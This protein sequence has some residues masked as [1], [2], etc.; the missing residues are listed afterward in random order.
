MFE[1][2]HLSDPHFTNN[3]D[4]F[5]FFNKGT[6]HFAEQIA[7]ALRDAGQKP[8]FVVASGDLTWDGDPTDFNLAKKFFKKLLT[9]LNLDVSKLLLIPG[10]HDI[11]WRRGQDKIADDKE[12][13]DAYRLFYEGL[14]QTDMSSDLTEI[15]VS[16]EATVVGLN[17]ASIESPNAAGIGYVGDEQWDECW[18][19]A[20]KDTAFNPSAVRIAVLHHHLVPVT[21]IEPH[22]TDKQFSLTL[23]AES[24]QSRLL[25]AGFTLVLHGHQHQPFLRLLSAPTLKQQ[26]CL[27]VAGAGSAGAGREKLGDGRRNH[28]QV[29]SIKD[30]EMAVQWY[31]LGSAGDPFAFMIGARYP[32]RMSDWPGEPPRIVSHARIAADKD[33]VLGRASIELSRAVQTTAQQIGGDH[34]LLSFF[35]GWI[36]QLAQQL[37]GDQSAL[38]VDAHYYRGCLSAFQSLGKHALAIADL[39]DDT[40]EFWNDQPDPL[41]TA[42]SE[43]L[44]LIA[45]EKMFDDL[46]LKK[47]HTLFLKHSARYKVWFDHVPFETEPRH[48]FGDRGRGRNLLLLDPD[49][50]GGYVN[51]KHGVFLRIAKNPALYSQA[52]AHYVEMRERS[53]EFDPT[54]STADLR[55]KWIQHHGFGRWNQDWK[56]MGTRTPDYFQ[57]YD[58]HIQTWIP[59]YNEF[60]KFAARHTMSSIYSALRRSPQA[61]RVLEIGFG[62]GALTKPVLTWLRTLDEPIA[63]LAAERVFERFLGVDCADQMLEIASRRLAGLLSGRASGRTLLRTGTAVDGFPLEVTN[64][65]PFHVICGSLVLHDLLEKKPSTERVQEVLVRLSTLLAP[66][67]VL[68]FADV[69]FD[70]NEKQKE[71]Q[72]ERWK[73]LM[74]QSGLLDSDVDSFLNFNREMV[75]TAD[76]ALIEEAAKNTQFGR[77]EL[78]RIPSLADAPF[79][80]LTLT[81]VPE[82]HPLDV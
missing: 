51:T 72:L 75:E 47:V 61:L 15:H 25:D 43:R 64:N 56:E 14:K 55:S 74:K 21:W 6:D 26:H 34:P 79:G 19:R 59:K 41:Q 57:N 24:L 42:V 27:L 54:W 78:M 82:G 31:E 3:N 69:F 45:W 28:F 67:G 22:L 20:Q 12:R 38:E 33:S 16:K 29:V 58:V 39:T 4:R 23:D 40:E 60:I 46:Y 32:F 49:V 10:N 36:E 68:L 62:T 9:L 71:R 37:Y 77:V 65:A 76:L 7:T 11:R 1:I 63:E 2:L 66:D 18:K 73:A 44:F 53:L 30:H 35:G 13:V 52:Q 48:V 80:V 17:S 8:S 81:K 70:G 50:V 5:Y